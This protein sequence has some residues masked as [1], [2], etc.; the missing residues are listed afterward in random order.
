MR[1]A[2]LMLAHKNLGQL[3]RLLNRLTKDFDVYLHLDKKWDVDVHHFEKY[4]NVFL[5]ERYTINWGSYQQVQA[6]AALFKMAFKKDYDYYLLI[7]GQDLPIKSNMEIAA[8]LEKNK[9]YSFVDYEAFPKKQWEKDFKGGKTRVVYYYGFDFKK[10]FV[11]LLAKKGLALI[12]YFQKKTG[13][14]RKLQPLQYY[15]GWNWVNLNRAAMTHIVNY[16]DNH[17]EFLKSFKYTLC[18]DE[19]WIQTVLMNSDNK[20]KNTELRYTDWRGCLENPKTLVMDH[21]D[22]MKESDA[23]FARKFDDAIDA[24]V[25]D[26]VYEMTDLKRVSVI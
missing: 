23:L 15:G 22:E 24:E 21:L 18:G 5:T 12:R 11:G 13:F 20:V 25:I 3:D 16:I 2:I 26:K 7:S 1:I 8:F 9:D 4:G 14:E 6:D 17:P 19:V 10:N